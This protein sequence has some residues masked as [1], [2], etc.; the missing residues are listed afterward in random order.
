MVDA[1]EK[2][3]GFKGPV[4]VDTRFSRSVR[5]VGFRG[6]A[7]EKKAG[8]QRYRWMKGLGNRAIAKRSGPR[9]QIAD[10]SAAEGL[11]KLAVDLARQRQRLIFF[12]ACEFQRWKS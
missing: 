11:L 9:L 10:P 4:F 2:N 3:R 7:F 5:A 12:C 8:P 6:D 1:V